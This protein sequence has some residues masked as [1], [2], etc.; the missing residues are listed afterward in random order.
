VCPGATECTAASPTEQA[1]VEP[2]SAP[3]LKARVSPDRARSTTCHCGAHTCSTTA[4]SSSRPSQTS[5]HWC[6]SRGTAGWRPP[7]PDLDVGVRLDGEAVQPDVRHRVD[8]FRLREA[9]AIAEGQERNP[10][11]QHQQSST[12]TRRGERL[13]ASPDFHSI[14][15]S[16]R[17]SSVLETSRPSAFAVF[18]LMYSS[19]LVTCWTGKSA[20]FSPLRIRPV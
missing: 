1:E 12:N 9:R 13:L 19:T 15:S 5:S 17:A 16:A 7:M 3:M 6:R 10:L 14:T 18:R 8:V 2:C 11:P 4:L 20:G